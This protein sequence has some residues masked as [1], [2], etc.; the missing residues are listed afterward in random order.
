MRR[1]SQQ[2]RCRFLEDL[3]GEERALRACVAAPS[4]NAL[5]ADAVADRRPGLVAAIVS[6]E[7]MGPPFGETPGVGSLDWGLTAA[8]ITYDPPRATANEVRAADPSSLRIPSLSRLPV[9]VV[10]GE[11]SIFATFSSAIVEFLYTAGADAEQLHLPDYGIFGN[12]HG[13]IYEKN[14]D[15]ALEPILR[16][17]AA[18]TSDAQRT[19]DP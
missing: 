3:S 14:S 17:L 1:A 8:P 6:I 11:T 18:H 13:L 10:T 15:Q 5:V 4:G 19:S 12:G 7:P 2:A 9:A 16:W